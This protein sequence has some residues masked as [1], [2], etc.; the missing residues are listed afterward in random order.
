M[1][2]KKLLKNIDWD[3]LR[4]MNS[5][6]IIEVDKPSESPNTTNGRNVPFPNEDDSCIFSL[7]FNKEVIFSKIG[8]I[9]TLGNSDNA[10][11]YA[12]CHGNASTQPPLRTG[13]SKEKKKHQIKKWTREAIIEKL[14]RHS[15]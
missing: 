5:S 14:Q 11:F 3:D 9:N 4:F 12:I 6:F 15:T 8:F 1:G 10:L 7:R 2:W 13:L